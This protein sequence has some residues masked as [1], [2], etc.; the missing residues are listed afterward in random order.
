MNTVGWAIQHRSRNQLDGYREWYEGAASVKKPAAIAGYLTKVFRTR[1]E[2]S[3]YIQQQY[4]YI[5]T[6]KDL[7]S[8]PHGWLMPRVVKVTVKIEPANNRKKSR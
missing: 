5:R 7:R 4:T 1:R 2:A 6:R 3:E 8:E